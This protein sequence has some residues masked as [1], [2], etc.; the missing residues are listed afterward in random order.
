MNIYDQIVAV[1]NGHEGEIL[2]SSQIKDMLFKKFGT[3]RNSVLPPDYCYNR[4]NKGIDF[5]KHIFIMINRN[6]YKYVGKNYPYSG[7]I[8]SRAKGTT[9]DTIVGEW[10]N[11]KYRLY[12]AHPK[13][14]PKTDKGTPVTS[15]AMGREQIQKLYEEY[16]EILELEANVF[17][18]KPT[19]TRH[20]IG[21]LGELKCALWTNG[22]LSHV[23]NQNGFDV[24]DSTKRKISV[25]TTAQKSGFISINKN[26]L[27]KADDLMII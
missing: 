26:T 21:R 4:I 18:Y 19:E 11:G 23:V 10:E 14:S 3:N 22:T 13:T 8:L 12:E 9:R 27:N 20:L 16:M 5:S 25:K 1:C 2:T 15:S 24:I 6:E 7:L 17:G